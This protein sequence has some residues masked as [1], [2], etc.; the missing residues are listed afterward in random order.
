MLCPVCHGEGVLWEQESDIVKPSLV[1]ADRNDTPI[2]EGDTLLET[3]IGEYGYF[4]QQCG[5]RLHVAKYKDLYDPAPEW[6]WREGWKTDRV[7]L[8]RRK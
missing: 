7:I 3:N 8:Y 6:D 5:D 4:L 1:V 2:A